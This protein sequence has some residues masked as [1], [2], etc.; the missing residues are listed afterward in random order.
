[1]AW[2]WQAIAAHCF[3]RGLTGK[4]ISEIE[5]GYVGLLETP[6]DWPRV[7]QGGAALFTSI[8]H[9]LNQYDDKLGPAGALTM[10]ARTRMLA[11]DNAKPAALEMLAELR[12]HRFARPLRPLT[13]LARLASRDFLRTEAEPEATP[14]RAFALLSHRL[15]GKVT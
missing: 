3:P 10:L 13:N 12:G 1:M 5:D 8:A 11:P 9:L 2:R 7:G 4:S 6:A 15:S 14:G